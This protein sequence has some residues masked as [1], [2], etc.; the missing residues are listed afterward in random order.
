MKPITRRDFIM[1]GAGGL[2]QLAYAKGERVPHKSGAKKRR[3]LFNW[4]GSVIHT[5]GRTVLPASYGPLTHEQFT[6]L[7]FTPI[8]NT[9]VDTVLFSFGSGN[10]AEYQSNVLEW[11][12]EADRF[13]FPESKAWYGGVEVDPKD[14]YLNPK[15]LADGGHNPPAVI[16]EECHK[17][18]L[19]AFVSLRMNDIHDGQHPKGTLPNPE[20]ASFKRI[21]PDWLVDDLDWGTALDFEHPRVRALKL[22]VVEEFFDRWDFDGIEL[23]WLRHS[24]YFRRGTERENA[25]YLTLFM[26]D[27]RKSLQTRAA[28]RGRPIEVAVRIPERVQ[29]CQEGGFEI[30]KWI[31]E[32]LVDML[33]LGQ[34]LTELPTLS[35][36]RGLM[37]VRKLP[38]Y[39]S[40]YCYGN[41]YRVSP[42]EVIRGSAANLWKDGADGLY[43]FNWFLY[44][45]W[46]KHLLNE[47]AD[48]KLLQNKDKHYTLAQR[49]DTIARE[50]GADYVRYNT[51][52]KDAP[53]P[54]DL[55][56]AQGVHSVHVPVADDFKISFPKSA[57]LWIAMDYSQPGD[58]LTVSVGDAVLDPAEVDVASSWQ[59]V[60]VQI[61][62]LP[63]NG[64][65]GFP[66][67]KPFEMRFQAIRL[68]VPIKALKPGHNK[69]SFKLNKRGPGSEKALQVRRIELVTRMSATRNMS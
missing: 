11:P 7:V 13:E 12:G 66:S 52:S 69:L 58:W 55:N 4:D 17:R 35:E 44:G 18:G 49:F 53:V 40:L 61:N 22:K 47:I 19:D 24:L 29:W 67:D 32:D 64:M 50:P 8:A 15:S 41:S 46:R 5:W 14:Q 1:M 54:F 36:F 3:L 6:S 57:E 60:G 26:R 9:A 25:K 21:N 38:I 10:V 39:P 30:D 43:T 31:A 2:A 23:D 34:G 51:V 42:D 27:V 37:K 62:P 28:K 45:S 48:P 65:I 16:V 33:I 56:E 68:Q 59:T 63:G 20:L